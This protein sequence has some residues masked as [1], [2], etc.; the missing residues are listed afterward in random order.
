MTDKKF[1]DTLEALLKKDSRIVSD[2]SK[3]ENE[4]YKLI[5]LP[6]YNE[7]R[8]EDFRMKYNEMLEVE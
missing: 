2:L 4:E 7:R 1:K 3:F 5:G 8:K 6:L